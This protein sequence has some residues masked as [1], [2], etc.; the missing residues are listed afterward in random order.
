[1]QPCCKGYVIK[2]CIKN[3]YRR[4]ATVL[5]SGWK[6]SC[7][8]NIRHPTVFLAIGDIPQQTAPQEGN[9]RANKPWNKSMS[10]IIS[11]SLSERKLFIFKAVSWNL[12][13]TALNKNAGHSGCKPSCLA[14]LCC[15]FYM[16]RRFP[17]TE[18]EGQSHPPHRPALLTLCITVTT[19]DNGARGT[20]ATFP[21]VSPT[22]SEFRFIKTVSDSMVKLCAPHCWLRLHA[23]HSNLWQ[24][25]W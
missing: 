25:S 11:L 13:M 15:L 3:S 4:L 17:A 12:L 1:M 8:G 6:E 9:E 16:R 18:G 21:E 19:W 2:F 7:R 14:V 20:A 22:K 23:F 24:P 10:S 5:C